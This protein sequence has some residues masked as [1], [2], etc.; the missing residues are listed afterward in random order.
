MPGC[1]E[2]SRNWTSALIGS[3]MLSTRGATETELLPATPSA[4]MVA[5]S[6]CPLGGKYLSDWNLLIAT[7]VRGPSC[8]SETPTSYPARSRA[9]CARR[10]MSPEIGFTVGR[11]T[12]VVVDPDR[13]ARP[14][15]GRLLTGAD[16][17]SF[18]VANGAHEAPR[19]TDRYIP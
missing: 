15:T 4:A 13:L 5:S 1:P 18:R 7:T 17:G 14:R 8:P 3:E 2:R 19:S 10:T 9:S 16:A 6:S 11:T 12:V